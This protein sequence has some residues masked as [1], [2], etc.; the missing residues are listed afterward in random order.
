MKFTIS[1]LFVVL[2]WSCKSETI[3]S[4]QVDSKNS[5][6]DS[7]YI[8][9]SITD[10]IL[11][12][13]AV[14]DESFEKIEALIEVPTTA[15]IETKDGA[16]RYLAILYPK[17]ELKITIE[18]DSIIQTNALGDSLLNYI[19]HS[20]NNFIQQNQNF[21]FTTPDYDSIV[22]LF[23]DFEAVRQSKI[24]QYSSRLSPAVK[25]IL[26][27]QNSARI[28]SFLFYFGRLIKQFPPNHPYFSFISD[29]DHNA[30]WAKTLPH[31]I[32]WKHEINYL[33]VHDS[34]ENQDEFLDYVTSQTDNA[35]LLDFLRVIYISEIIAHPSYWRKHQPNLN[36]QNLRELIAKEKTN[37]Y[38]KLLINPSDAFFSTQKGQIAYDFEAEQV[39]GS[40]VKLS[41]YKGKVVFIDS[42]ATWCAPC[43]SHRPKVVEL[44]NKYADDDRVEI[45]M[46]SMD[47]K[48]S[49]WINFLEKRDDL[50]QKGDLII[51]EGIKKEYRKRYNVQL[52]PR[53]ILI[54][55]DGVIINSNI[56]EP[57]RNVEQL[58]EHELTKM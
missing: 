17:K 44:A 54:D 30:P 19:W 33:M 21:I 31:N 8:V 41:D 47:S 32:L 39:D 26:L 5:S 4:I 28:H 14:Q 58:I 56:S 18:A 27:Y 23:Q 53:Y 1:I 55:Q 6:I 20:N 35:D 51:P 3:Y 7:L 36:S 42:W 24:E 57:S 11:S 29:I 40:K 46:I 43:I 38:Y 16:Q 45:L 50:N 15:S 13:M 9:E 37:T 10:E 52:I 25:E 34:I 48:K 22:Q 2:L 12:K 49:K